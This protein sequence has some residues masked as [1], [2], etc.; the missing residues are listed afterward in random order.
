MN[1]PTGTWIRHYMA[2]STPERNKI[3][4]SIY[5]QR[6]GY[7]QSTNKYWVIFIVVL[8]IT[9]VLYIIRNR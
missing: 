7:E 2:K 9:I 6:C 1:S 3:L 5:I 8:I 4:H